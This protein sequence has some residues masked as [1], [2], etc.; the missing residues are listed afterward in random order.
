IKACPPPVNI[1]TGRQDILN[2]MHG[3]FSNDIGKRH[4]FVLYGL[5]GA[6][7]SQIA[8]K[9][10]EISQHERKPKRFSDVF[11][12]DAS[13]TETINADFKN[14]AHAKG[15]EESLRDALQ[16]LASQHDEWLLLFNNADDTTLNM[17]NYFPSC[18]YGNILITT[19]NRSICSHTSGP[20]AYYAVSNMAPNDAQLLLLTRSHLLE[21]TTH[22]MKETATEIV[23]ELGYLALAIVQAGAYIFSLN[24]SLGQYLDM[25]HVH[26]L[27]LLKESADD[28]QSMDDYEFTIYTTWKMSFKKLAE[29]EGAA[30]LLQLCAFLHYDG[31]SENIF[32]KAAANIASYTTK[33]FDEEEGFIHISKARD[34]LHSYQ[35][36]GG[37][38]DS[39]RFHRNIMDIQKYSLIEFDQAN[40]TYSIHPLV[41]AW[42]QTI[43]NSEV[44]QTC[45]Q[46]ILGIA[47]N[48][49]YESE[50][51]A[52]RRTLL[53][54]IETACQSQS[55]R[56]YIAEK[57]ALV[58]YES[59]L[60]MEAEELEVQVIDLQKRL[61]GPEHPDTLSSIAIL[62]LTYQKQG[63]WK[64]AEELGVQVVD[65]RKRLLGPEHPDT[66]QGMANLAATYHKQGRWMEAEE[67]YVQ[68]VELRKRLM[69]PE[70]PNTLLNMGNLAETYCNQGQWKEA[71]ELEVQVV[72][73]QKRLLGPE[74]PDTLLSMANLAE[75]YLQQ[76]Q[77]KE[78]EELGVQVVDL[79]KR[80]LGLEHPDTLKGM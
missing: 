57:F 80:L 30:A 42:T 53:P 51:Y 15:V 47:I 60:W 68:V 22:E 19:R 44:F 78:A 6:G 70:H 14:I 7:K 28:V 29:S 16:W 38:W 79:Q 66:L 72:D 3:Y 59:G 77:W 54:H 36:D 17:G 8:Y 73:I 46:S 26:H 27:Q 1:F 35:G 50:D 43:P 62:S 65:L 37:S 2:Q 10:V 9:F 61:L 64:E 25:Y 52:F 58:Y 12:I 49:R 48:W 20:Q 67:L 33:I 24:F 23:K 18:S 11:F 13:T 69:G 63:R 76:G 45:A 41:H 55:T 32:M 74:H 4:I 31:I 56:V 5:G 21:G 75:I 71:E 34:F 39:W 40:Q